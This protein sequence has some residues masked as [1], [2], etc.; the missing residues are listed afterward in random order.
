[1]RVFREFD[2]FR[3]STS[4]DKIKPTI[5]GGLISMACMAVSNHA[6]SLRVDPRHLDL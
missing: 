6:Y 2:Y 3:K 5:I 1:M 4:P